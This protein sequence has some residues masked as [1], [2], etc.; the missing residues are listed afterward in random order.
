MT[1]KKKKFE[2]MAVK[3]VLAVRFLLVFG[4]MFVECRRGPP[5]RPG[6]CGMCFVLL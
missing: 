6:M 4:G 2:V 1:N 5:R 3:F